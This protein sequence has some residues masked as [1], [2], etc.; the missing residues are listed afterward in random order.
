M[1]RRPSGPVDAVPRRYLDQDSRLEVAVIP[2]E[3]VTVRLIV[4]AR[5]RLEL[6]RVL[7]LILAAPDEHRLGVQVNAVDD[8]GRQH[9]LLTE[10]PGAGVDD[11]VRAPHLF[12]ALVDLADATVRGLDRKPDEL[13]TCEGSLGPERPDVG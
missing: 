4:A 3:A 10:D 9:D 2:A 11:Q 7:D 5:F 6:G 8:A 12:G 1:H 13:R